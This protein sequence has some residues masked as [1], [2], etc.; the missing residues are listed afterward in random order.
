[1]FKKSVA[2]KT[3]LAALTILAGCVNAASTEPL[4]TQKPS[5]PDSNTVSTK[6]QVAIEADI[7]TIF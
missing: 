7:D 1:M 5:A 3:F 2:G 6:T 4:Q